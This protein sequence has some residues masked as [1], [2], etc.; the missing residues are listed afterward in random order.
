MEEGCSGVLKQ[1]FG[2][3]DASAPESTTARTTVEE[4][5]RETGAIRGMA[6]PRR[7]SFLS[8]AAACRARLVV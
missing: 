3:T 6:L 7:L 4:A 2:A 5:V 1:P 8:R